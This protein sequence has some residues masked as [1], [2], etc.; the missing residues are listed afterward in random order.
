MSAM[1]AKPLEARQL[2]A[3]ARAIE[4]GAR[5]YCVV[6]QCVYRAPSV[7]RPGQAHTLERGRDGWR[8]NCEGYYWTGICL[9][10]GALERRAEREKWS[11][12]FKVAPKLDA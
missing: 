6:P 2:E 7:S 11:D 12:G 9:H 4:K 10:L 3:R 1:I 5:L 8:C